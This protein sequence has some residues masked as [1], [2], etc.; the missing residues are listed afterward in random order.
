M[1]RVEKCENGHF[2]DG[3]LYDACPYCKPKEERKIG[4]TKCENGHFYDAGRHSKCPLCPSEERIEAFHEPLSG[5]VP[6]SGDTENDSYIFISYSHK[7]TDQMNEIRRILDDNGYAYWFDDGIRSGVEWTNYLYK[8]IKNCAQFLLLMSRDAELSENVCDEVYVAQKTK[9]DFVIIFLEDFELDSGLDMRIGRKHRILKP[10]FSSRNEFE[11]RLCYDLSDKAK[12]KTEKLS[13]LSESDA[14]NQVRKKYEIV[15]VISEKRKRKT[16]LGKNLTTGIPVFIKM[17]MFDEA[18]SDSKLPFRNEVNALR[19]CVSPYLPQLLDLYEDSRCGYIVENYLDGQKLSQIRDLSERDALN[20]MI[21]L[22][23]A[24]DSLHK[25]GILHCD[26]KMDNIVVSPHSDAFLIDLNSS[27][28][29]NNFNY[30]WSTGT[31]G[32]AAPE[33]YERQYRPDVRT[34]IY[35]LGKVFANMLQNRSD[36]YGESTKEKPFTDEIDTSP[37]GA[38][39]SLLYGT[40]VLKAPAV[41][42]DTKINPR[43]KK[44]IDKMT[45]ERKDDRYRS[46]AELKKALE[47]CRL[48]LEFEELIAD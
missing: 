11:K 34:D 41:R 24:V 27:M 45:A 32:Y 42:S 20:I 22:S 17:Y 16:I 12:K 5:S 46:V 23:H 21:Q 10:M 40:Q 7:N 35:S 28:S 36:A 19:S 9:K 29:L 44:I 2:Y 43:I 3:D 15:K 8:K 25:S 47:K 30:G 18:S 39:T 4:I 33:Q 1:P 14:F 6:E 38:R 13:E 37:F 31:V 26:I 48:I